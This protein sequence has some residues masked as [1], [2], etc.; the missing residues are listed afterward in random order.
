M[1]SAGYIISAVTDYAK[2]SG[3]SNYLIGFL[4][5]SLGTSL[6]EL[7]TAFVASFKNA[8]NLIIGN[9]IGANILDVTVV[10]G[11]TAIIGRKIFVHGK[12]LDKTLFTVL[13]MAMLPLMLGAD[14]KISAIE[15]W[16]LVTAFILYI[17]L[18]L[19]K[20][21]QFG[22]LTKQLLWKDIW[23]DMA[24]ISLS[25]VTL[26]LSSNWLI[27]SAIRIAS[28]LNVPQFSL[29]LVLVA[30]ATT[31][32]EL[33]VEIRSILRGATGIAF[34]D[35]LGSVVVNS[36]LVIGIAAIINP[37][38]VEPSSFISAAF[39]MV[40][41]VYIALLFIKKKE[42]TWQEGVGVLMLYLT[43]LITEG[44]AGFL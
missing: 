33:S 38:N 42:I 27:Q 35:I 9:V 44:I 18:L 22:K 34:G 7:T 3:V 1:L 43:F 32:P 16:V 21:G 19:K 14:G 37:I 25:I 12:I 28:I 30:L 4:V 11:V 10:L 17:F 8:G 13:G 24:I 26:L 2:K 41:T 5:V 40:T 20:E 39:F 29:G 15:G 31:V 23:Q 36:S 6:P